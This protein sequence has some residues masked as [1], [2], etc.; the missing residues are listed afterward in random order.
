MDPIMYVAKDEHDEVD[1]ILV[2][3]MVETAKKVYE[4]F[5]IPAKMIFDEDAR[6]LHESATVFFACKKGFDATR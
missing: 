3:R 5:K 1:R 4:R 6:R 2:E